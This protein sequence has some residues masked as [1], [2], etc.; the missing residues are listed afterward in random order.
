MLIT[1][2]GH[3]GGHTCMT[4][5]GLYC[6]AYLLQSESLACA[7]QYIC[8]NYW[9]VLSCTSSTITIIG[10]Y[11]SVHVPQPLACTVQYI[12]H[13]Y[14]PVHLLQSQSLACIVQYICHNHWPVLS[15]T[16]AIITGL[17]CPVHLPQSLACTVQNIC[18]NH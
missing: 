9:L 10:L 1:N 6:P 5:T 11:C 13:N 2:G 7:V 3:G 18:H 15:S 17:Y 16:S 4:V 8:H 12:C 14:W